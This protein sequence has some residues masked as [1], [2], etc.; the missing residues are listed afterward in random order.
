M[1]KWLWLSSLLITAFVF[2]M[3]VPSVFGQEAQESGSLVPV[4]PAKIKKT[5]E[6]LYVDV[7]DQSFYEEGVQFLR[8]PELFRKVAFSKIPARDVNVYDEVP[9]SL[10]FTNRQGKSPLSR[11]NLQKGPGGVLPAPGI[12]TV[13]RGK[14]EGIAPGFFI[15]DSNGQE[16]LLKFDPSDYPKM[17]TAAESISSRI[18][19]ALGYNVPTYHPV[20]FKLEDIEVDPRATYYDE[21]G[22]KK[23]LSKRRIEDL[24]LFVARDSDETYRASASLILQGVIKG[25]FHMDG[26][27]KEDPNDRIPHRYLR[28]IRAL[29]IFGSWVN[30]YDLKSGNTLDVLETV[31]GREVLKHYLIDFGSTI[32]S[33]AVDP[34]PPHFGHE[35][36]F[37]FVEFYKSIFSLGFREKSWQKRWDE[38]ERKVSI[39][40]LG[41][42]DNRH[43]DPG[44]WKS[45]LPYHA[46]KDL[47]T[48]DAYWAAKTI[49]SFRDEDI[50]ALVET[51]QFSDSKVKEALIK[52]LIERR[53][54]IGAYW[55]EKS[56]P[57]DWIKISQESSGFKVQGTD[58]SVHYGLVPP[59]RRYRF[60]VLKSH[61]RSESN[62]PSVLLDDSSLARF[63]NPFV[64]S[65]RVKNS[66]GKWGKRLLLNFKREP[67]ELKLL[68]IERDL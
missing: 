23:P 21:T 35:H 42:F 12:W 26:Y 18:F 57:V 10:F 45:Q 52:L 50:E 51:G 68:K 67:N 17:S 64:L 28:E 4:D 33:A 44:R 22:F 34:K 2:L 59:N 32:G 36:M 7:F 54:I 8:L 66:E 6:S 11:G 61:F 62:E 30:Y 13:T 5:K 65:C 48:S 31:S 38:N 19:H 25:P 60:Q 63:P 56:C 29:R 1:K 37:D 39:S 16:F 46:F 40:G 24:L 20:K 49:L 55:L 41:Y 14:V 47:T 9:D 3:P 43:F 15:K 58:L 27:R 53:D